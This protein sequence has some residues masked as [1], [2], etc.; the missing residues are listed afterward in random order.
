LTEDDLEQLPTVGKP[1]HEDPDDDDDDVKWPQL[2]TSAVKKGLQVADA[3]GRV[4]LCDWPL[5]G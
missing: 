4:F 1:E 3:L 5:H 2:T